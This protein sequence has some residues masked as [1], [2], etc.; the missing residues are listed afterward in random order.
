MRN[1][2]STY[3]DIAHFLESR[4]Q[5]LELLFYTL[6]TTPLLSFALYE[7]GNWIPFLCVTAIGIVFCIIYVLFICW[8]TWNLWCLRHPCPDEDTQEQISTRS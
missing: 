3:E 4:K 8:H 2:N 6:I 1:R 5:H 7:S